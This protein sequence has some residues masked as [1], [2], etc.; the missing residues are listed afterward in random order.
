MIKMLQEAPVFEYDSQL[1]EVK[2]NATLDRADSSTFEYAKQGKVCY[3]R[4]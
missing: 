4:L 3:N 2:Y 1:D